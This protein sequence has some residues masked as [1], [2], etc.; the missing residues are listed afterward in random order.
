M[1]GFYS[2]ES[3]S[4]RTC[5]PSPSSAN[6]CGPAET[7]LVVG[8]DPVFR[9][10]EAQIFCDLGYKVLK[11]GSSAEALH[12]AGVATTIHLLFTDFWMPEA[13]ALEL[14]RQFRTVHPSIPALL[15]SDSVPVMESQAGDLHQ[16]AILEKPF[17]PHELIYKVRMLLDQVA[18]LPLRPIKDKS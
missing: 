11:A 2:D 18:P 7:L 16:L 4:D 8:D 10:L 9:E 3:K 6:I 15:V 14:T 1:K 5:S 12:L 17:T 13:D